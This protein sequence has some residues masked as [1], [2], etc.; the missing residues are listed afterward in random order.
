MGVIIQVLQLPFIGQYLLWLNDKRWVVKIEKETADTSSK[1][2]AL[3]WAAQK[4]FWWKMSFLDVSKD[5]NISTIIGDI[6]KKKQ[7][8]QKTNPLQIRC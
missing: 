7:K 6:Y 5:G 4:D 8:K 2:R 1:M 3:C